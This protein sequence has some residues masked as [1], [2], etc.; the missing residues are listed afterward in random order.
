[1]EAV[2][3]HQAADSGITNAAGDFGPKPRGFAIQG[4]FHAA[5]RVSFLDGGATAFHA[6]DINI[7]Y[8]P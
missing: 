8:S 5:E 2:A 4:V 1:M 6:G 7:D 3:V